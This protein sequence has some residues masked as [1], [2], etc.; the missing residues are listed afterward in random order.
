MKWLD[1]YEVV[2][3][4]GQASRLYTR[5]AWRGMTGEQRQ[6]A[7]DAG[8]RVRGIRYH[9]DDRP[10]LYLGASSLDDGATWTLW[11]ARTTPPS[12]LMVGVPTLDLAQKMGNV[13][14]QSRAFRLVLGAGMVGAA[15]VAA[16]A[17][18]WRRERAA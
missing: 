2:V 3:Q 8:G 1:S 11:D 10:W 18:V 7:A 12:P 4:A 15:T 13:A 17:S 9:L 16:L 5:S 6:A 14:A